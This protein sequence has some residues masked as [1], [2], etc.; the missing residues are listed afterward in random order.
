MSDT[1]VTPA[2]NDSDS[3]SSRQDPQIQN[4][5]EKR[6]RQQKI[7][8]TKTYQQDNL[9]Y[10]DNIETQ[11]DYEGIVFHNINGIKDKHNWF[12]ILW[13]VKEL[14]ITCF[15]FAELNT[16]M[17]GYQYHK[18]NDITRKVFR[19]SKSETSESDIRMDTD[20]KQGGTS[21]TIVDKWQ[22]RVAERG[23]N[24]KGL[25]RWSYLVLSSNC[26]KLAIITAYR[27]CKTQG[28]TTAWTQQWLM[29]REDQKNPDPILQFRKD[30]DDQ[31]SKWKTKGYKIILLLDANEEIG[32]NPGGLGQVIAK[33]GLFDI[34]SNQHVAESYP[35][36]YIQGTQRI[37][38][39]FGTERVLK[40]CKSSG[41]LPFCYGYP[42]DHRAIF[43]RINLPSILSSEI[44]A[45]ETTAT[46]LMYSATP[47]E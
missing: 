22:S 8:N 36:T 4:A 6:L 35:N 32:N 3:T 15:G 28:P 12:Q 34:L 26:R 16:L 30:L 1:E 39:I 18:W 27:P 29:L 47:K 33:N 42:S 44:H 10:G 31:L 25:G 14:N 40:N 46:C 11:S 20:Y 21:T 45:A 19:V 2:S 24:D 9:P 5:N 7:C 41:M 23:S 13:T 38:Y 17:K 43:I 37:D